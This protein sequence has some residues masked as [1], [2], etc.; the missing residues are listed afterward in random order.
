[1]RGQGGGQTCGSVC[2]CRGHGGQVSS[3]ECRAAAVVQI[4]KMALKHSGSTSCA[5]AVHP[6]VCPVTLSGYVD[7]AWETGPESKGLFL[8]RAVPFKT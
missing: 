4:G 1:M 8:G 6:G 2:L 7:R 3:E 5:Q